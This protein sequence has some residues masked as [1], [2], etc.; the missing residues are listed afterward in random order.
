MKT[1]EFKSPQLV[2]Q[3]SD[4]FVSTTSNQIVKDLRSR[5]LPSARYGRAAESTAGLETCF[6]HTAN[7]P[8]KEMPMQLKK[9]Q[10]LKR[11]KQEGR[12]R[13]EQDSSGVLLPFLTE[14]L[15][16]NL[17]PQAA[18]GNRVSHHLLKTLN[19]V[20]LVNIAKD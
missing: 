7:S 16:F 6:S 2:T 20:V 11:A 12:I 4:E 1:L 15:S 3:N 18:L 17:S 5:K 10:K 14:D 19:S 13:S 9:F 8:L